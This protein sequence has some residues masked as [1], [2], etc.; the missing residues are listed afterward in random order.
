MQK[1]GF[2]ITRVVYV[3]LEQ[4]FRK[5]KNKFNCSLSVNIRLE[6]RIYSPIIYTNCNSYPLCILNAKHLAP[7]TF[8]YKLR[9]FLEI[10]ELSLL[11]HIILP[12]L[13]CVRRVCH[14]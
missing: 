11:K 13:T 4:Y 14:L 3:F 5:K 2:L 7:A 1:A 10:L 12:T 6:Y 9:Y 8:F